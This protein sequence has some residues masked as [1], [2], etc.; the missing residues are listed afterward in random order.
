MTHF[1]QSVPTS[2]TRVH[3]LHDQ[4]L[5][6]ATPH[7]TRADR[8]RLA[9][10]VIGGI[11]LA[12][13]FTA[14]GVQIRAGWESHRDWVVPV[15]AQGAAIAGVAAAYLVIRGRTREAGVGFILLILTLAIVGANFLRGID[16]EGP[17]TLR[18]WFSVVSGILYGASMLAFIVGW[19]YVEL[20]EPTRP[21]QPEL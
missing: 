13:V 10:I 9:P 2:P 3:E 7:K 15:I 16:T 11:I 4:T 8:L 12:V 18:D 1:G 17:D 6:P 5:L 20:R 21:K 19:L 14:I